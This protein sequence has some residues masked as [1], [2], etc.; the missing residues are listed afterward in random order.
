MIPIPEEEYRSLFEEDRILDSGDRTEFPTGAVRDMHEG[1]GRMDLLPWNA[2][3]EVSRHCEAG[4]KKYGENNIR[5]G[6][7]LHSL[8]DSGIRH[9][10]K[11]LCGMT[12]EA[13]LTAACWNLLWALEFLTTREDLIDVPWKKPD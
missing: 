11:Y 12:D 7:P 10:A 13:H 4:A 9:A 1:K 2:I 8:L 5:L 6:V 3:M